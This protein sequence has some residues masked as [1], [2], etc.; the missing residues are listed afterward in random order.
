MNKLPFF[1][2]HSLLP[3]FVVPRARVGENFARKSKLLDF[4]VVHVPSRCD[5]LVL[6]SS[7]IFW[8]LVTGRRTADDSE[9]GAIWCRFDESEE[10]APRKEAN[11]CTTESHGWIF[12]SINTGD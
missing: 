7:L 8:S 9:A 5:T 2:T 3:K 12:H 6:L 4:V 10:L 11:K 1:L